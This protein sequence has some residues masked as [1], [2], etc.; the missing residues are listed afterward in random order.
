MSSIAF[1]SVDKTV[2]VG[3]RERA[4]CAVFI[5]RF[6]A[7]IVDIEGMMMFDGPR[8][9]AICHALKITSHTNLRYVLSTNFDSTRTIDGEEWNLFNCALNTMVV[10]GS[11]P[12]KFIARVHAQCEIHAWVDGPNRKW[13]A[14]IVDEGVKIGVLRKETQGYEGWE[15]VAKLLHESDEG[16]VVMSYSVCDSFPPY[17][18]EKDDGYM[19]WDEGMEWLRNQKGGLEMK[20]DD[21]NDFYFGD[22]K[23]AFDLI[24]KLESLPTT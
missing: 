16:E 15:E 13:F 19:T 10:L 11:D 23:T 14:D 5:D 3:G 18:H 17:D 22:G 4:Y 1:H 9:N 12:M 6:F 20:S 8:K 21:W 7:G 24:K 2:R